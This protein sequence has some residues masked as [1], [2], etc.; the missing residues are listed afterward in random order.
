MSILCE[1]EC[2]YL[3]PND[4]S[5]GIDLGVKE[6]AVCSNGERIANPKFLEKSEKHAK[7]IQRQV[8]RKK[9]GSKRRRKARLRLS[10]QHEKTRNRRR[11]YIHR[12]TNRIVS[13][14]QA[15]CV[16]DLN[17]QGM[18][19]NHNLAKSIGSASFGEIVRQLEYKSGWYGRGFV[20]IPRFYPS[21]KRCNHCGYVYKGLTLDE[22]EWECPNCHEEVD[23]DFNASLNIEEKGMEILSGVGDM[24]DV[25]QKGGEVVA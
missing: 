16:E 23:R 14:N 22:R 4:E 5:I 17:V 8:S 15:I 12:F 6:M 2:A 7:F 21:S 13:E 19:A 1:E 3:P 24:S 20:K 11:N 10:R 18:M 9:K 25:K